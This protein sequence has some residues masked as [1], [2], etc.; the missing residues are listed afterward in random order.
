MAIATEEDEIRADLIGGRIVAAEIHG[1]EI[2]WIRLH[3]G[4]TIRFGW[5]VGSEHTRVGLEV[6]RRDPATGGICGA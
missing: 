6:V 5:R 3:N 2:E 4:V 1:R